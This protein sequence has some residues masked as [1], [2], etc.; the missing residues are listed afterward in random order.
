M[1]MEVFRAMSPEQTEDGSEQC[2]DNPNVSELPVRRFKLPDRST[3]AT[4]HECLNCGAT[5]D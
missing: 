1:E 5:F 4:Y 3:R 2:C